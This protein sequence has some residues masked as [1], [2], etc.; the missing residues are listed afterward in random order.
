[1]KT[2]LKRI[3]GT[4]HFM[5]V[6]FDEKSMEIEHTLYTSYGEVIT[7]KHVRLKKPKPVK[8]L[9]NCDINNLSCTLYEIL[10]E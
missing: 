4:P 5:K 9:T 6:L 3:A 8:R 2:P 7:V 10:K 1:M